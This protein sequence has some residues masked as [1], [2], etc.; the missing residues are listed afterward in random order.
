MKRLPAF[1]LLAIA[2]VYALPS[3]GAP[4]RGNRWFFGGGIGLGFGTIDYVDIAPLVGYRVTEDFSVGG[5]LSWRYRSDDRFQ[6]SLN[7]NDYGAGLF[8]RY[9]I[10]SPLYLQAE[11]EYLSYEFVRFDGTSD[12]DEFDSVFGG[13]GFAQPL[14][15]RS[16]FFVTALYNFSYSSGEPGP[17][18]EPW[19]VRAGVSF[20]F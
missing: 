16:T 19:V 12:R 13:F 6:P 3:F 8:A 4:P 20:G 10:L 17:Y 11:Y 1:V 18:S 5:R 14:G 15:G 7:T 9:R 2:L